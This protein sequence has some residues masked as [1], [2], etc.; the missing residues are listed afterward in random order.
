[1]VYSREQQISN[2]VSGKFL[3]SPPKRNR[4]ELAS[5]SAR[6]PRFPLNLLN[7]FA[8][9]KARLKTPLEGNFRY[10]GNKE[11]YSILKTCL[12]IPVLFST[13]FSLFLNIIVF[14]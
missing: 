13:K 7:T 12:K 11:I 10:L 4:N 8:Y 14:K 2:L 3:T 1:M 6:Q 5:P 9:A